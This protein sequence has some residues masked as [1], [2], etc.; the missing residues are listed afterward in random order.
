MKDREMQ[1]WGEGEERGMGLNKKR[2]KKTRWVPRA[3]RNESNSP[4]H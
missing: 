2:K 1:W 4:A 3:L